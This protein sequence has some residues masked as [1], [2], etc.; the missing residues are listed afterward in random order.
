MAAR[1]RAVTVG[2]LLSTKF[3]E[4]RF[5]GEWHDAFGDPEL[6][7]SWL[8]WGNPTNGKTRFALQL[9]KYFAS[10]GIKVDYDS[11]EEGVS[12]SLKR[13]IREEGMTE[14]ARRFQVLDKMPIEELDQRLSRRKSA[15]VVFID[16]IQ[17]TGMSYTDYKH[18][19]DKHRTK[20]FVLVSHA[21][22]RYPEGKTAKKIRYDAFVKIWIEGYRAFPESRYGGGEPYTI[23]EEGADRCIHAK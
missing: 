2:E 9:A 15:A 16:S 12:K 4:L 6:T 10:F 23:W 22:G 20:L 1:K 8:I 14:V 18:L 7:G 11:L 13:A 3:N 17:Y 21:E 19:R 5:E